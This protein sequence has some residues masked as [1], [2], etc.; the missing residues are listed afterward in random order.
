MSSPA[1]SPAVVDLRVNNVVCN[2]TMRAGID[3]SWLAIAI[4]GRLGKKVFPACVSLCRQPRT[5]NSTFASGEMV[6]TGAKT[7]GDALLSAILLIMRI[8]KVMNR[9][10]L[11]AHHFQ[12]QNIVLSGHMGFQLDMKRLYKEQ[13]IFCT[14]DPICFAGLTYRVRD[15]S[16]NKK[17]SLVW[18]KSGAFLMPGQ[19]SIENGKRAFD[20]LEIAD[21]M[22]RYR[23]TAANL[24]LESNPVS[25]QI[26]PTRGIAWRQNQNNQRSRK[27]KT[28]STKQSKGMAKEVESNRRYVASGTCTASNAKGSSKKRRL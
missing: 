17:V 27:R 16:T 19:K 11:F 6:I 15:P 5:T 2:M 28:P 3:V 8:R 14:Y 4:N 21:M 13:Q 18:F 26:E 25:K 12:V 7:S 10:D 22:S 23:Q 1:S 9:F 20:K 24:E